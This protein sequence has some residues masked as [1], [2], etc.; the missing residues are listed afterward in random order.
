VLVFDHDVHHGNGTQD[1]FYGSREVL[2][3]SFHLSN[4]YPGTGDVEEIGEAAGKGFTM[5]APLEKGDGDA[6]V[7]SLLENVFLPTA[8]EFKPD[9]VL[10]SSGFDSLE[11]DPLGGL[12][13][14]PSFFGEMARA[15]SQ[16][17][18]RLVAFLEGGYQ[19]DRIGEASVALLRGIDAPPKSVNGEA[20]AAPSEGTL[21]A[22]LAPHW[23]SLR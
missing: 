6:E 17:Q 22:T 7:R 8:R 21:R 23:S 14:S 5:N 3:Q 20:K 12:R 9:L 19:L 1:I 10:F 13:L 4:H 15:F 18:P 11:G 2:Y 16:V